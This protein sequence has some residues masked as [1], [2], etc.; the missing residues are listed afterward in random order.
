MLEVLAMLAGGILLI[1]MLVGFASFMH[2]LIKPVVD[3]MCPPSLVPEYETRD[4]HDLAAA[5]LQR[6]KKVRDAEW[7]EHR[8]FRE[9]R[10]LARE[11]QEQKDLLD[12]VRAKRD[13]AAAER[14]LQESRRYRIDAESRLAKARHEENQQEI[15]FWEANL[16]CSQASERANATL[17]DCRRMRLES[18][19]VCQPL[20]AK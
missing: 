2:G 17:L 11:H 4:A 3:W 12:L 16:R 1:L 10:A 20:Q 18:L 8:K 15:P 9:E 13:L 19:G 6:R 14:D 5:E 7:R